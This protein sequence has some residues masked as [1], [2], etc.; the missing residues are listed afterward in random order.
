MVLLIYPIKQFL[1]PENMNGAN[2]GDI[3]D[4]SIIDKKNNIAKIIKIVESKP[5]L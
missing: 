5:I 3:V 4:Y 1:Y 2:N